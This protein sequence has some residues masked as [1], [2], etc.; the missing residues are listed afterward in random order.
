MES[1]VKLATG[2]NVSGWI[3]VGITITL[4]AICTFGLL[5]YYREHSVRWTYSIV[6][7]IAW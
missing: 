2:S 5:L 3:L 7:Y 1:L 4:V 6:I